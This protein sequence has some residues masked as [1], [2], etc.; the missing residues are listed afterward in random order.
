MKYFYATV[1]MFIVAVAVSGYSAT[2]SDNNNPNPKEL[3]LQC[4]RFSTDQMSAVFGYIYVIG[5]LYSLII[6]KTTAQGIC[7]NAPTESLRITCQQITNWA[8][9]TRSV[10][11]APASQSIG[12]LSLPTNAYECKDIACLCDFFR[13][14]GGSTCVLANGQPLRKAVRKEYRVLTDNERQRFHAAM[15]AIKNNSEYDTISRIHSQ[16]VTSPGAHSGPAFLP[17]HREFIKSIRVIFLDLR[18]EIA[19]RRVDPT[20][21]LPYWDSTLDARIPNPRDSSLWSNELMGI[22]SSDG[23]VRTGVFRNWLTVDGRRVFTRSVGATGNLMM[24]RDVTTVITASD[25][26]Q[27]LA[28]TAPQSVVELIH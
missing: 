9:N 7:D 24:E 26:R 22:D 1:L 5:L 11:A 12:I 15:W 19:L 3:N 4:Y 23:T 25:Y 6:N 2:R 14:T 18:L 10:A 13:G 8:A 28:F 27:I 20:V 16:Y 17:W 21:A